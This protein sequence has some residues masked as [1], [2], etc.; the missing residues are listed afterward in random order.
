MCSTPVCISSAPSLSIFRLH[1]GTQQLMHR[2]KM[3]VVV[4]SCLRLVGT[5]KVSFNDHR[6]RIDA[7]SHSLGKLTGRLGVPVVTLDRLGHNIRDHRNVSKG[8]PRLDSLHRSKTVRRSTSVMYFVRHP[9]CC[10][11]CSSRGKGSLR[12]VTRVVVTGRH[13]NTMNSMLLHFH[14]RFTHFRGPSSSIVIPVPNRTPNVVHSGVGNNNG[15]MPP[16]SPSTTPTSGG[17]FKTPVLRKPL[18][19]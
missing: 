16:P 9:R 6:R 14:N 17:P 7:V 18:P 5:D 13:G 15:D 11:V 12:N 1:A 2:R 19:F 8:H 3:G 4:V 10:G